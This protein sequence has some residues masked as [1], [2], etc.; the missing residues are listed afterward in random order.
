M[1]QVHA[2]LNRGGS[3]PKNRYRHFFEG[4]YKLSD[5]LTWANS[6]NTPGGSGGTVDGFVHVE[7]EDTLRVLTDESWSDSAAARV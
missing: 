4:V 2:P 1:A 5:A 6:I 3:E 7:K